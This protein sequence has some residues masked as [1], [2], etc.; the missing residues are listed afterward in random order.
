MWQSAIQATEKLFRD[1]SKPKNSIGHAVAMLSEFLNDKLKRNE[2]IIIPSSSSSVS[3]FFR[4]NVGD[5]GERKR[6]SQSASRR[7]SIRSQWRIPEGEEFEIVFAVHP[8]LWLISRVE[9]SSVAIERQALAMG[10][11][12]RAAAPRR[13]LCAAL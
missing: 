3:S 1:R 12:G 9:N 8:P 2:S 13:R 11:R 5:S 4:D 7:V 10:R 6:A